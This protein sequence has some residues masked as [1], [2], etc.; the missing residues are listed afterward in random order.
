MEDV[1]QDLED[2]ILSGH[3]T[4]EARLKAGIL[5]E[6]GVQ[7]PFQLSGREFNRAAERYYRETLRRKQLVESLEIFRR[8]LKKLTGTANHESA[9]SGTVRDL[10][11]LKR[12]Q[13]R[14][15]AGTATACELQSL[16]HMVIGVEAKQAR[17]TGA[18]S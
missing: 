12:M 8:Q 6:A 9:R 2:R 10:E 7:D 14:L 5:E 17:K 11:I 4:A 13:P 15:L 16:I 1:L 3:R 18:L